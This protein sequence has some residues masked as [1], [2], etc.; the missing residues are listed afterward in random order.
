MDAMRKI[1][2]QQQNHLESER[3]WRH[4]H[5]TTGCSIVAMIDV[6]HIGGNVTVLMTAATVP[7]KPAVPIILCQR[8]SQ[9]QPFQSKDVYRINLCAMRDDVWPNRMYAMVFPTAQMVKTKQIVRLKDAVAI[10]SGLSNTSSILLVIIIA[11][12]RSYRHTVTPNS[13]RHNY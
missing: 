6:C 10:N 3:T 1:V 8:P 12:Q 11:I 7:M 2:Q 4:Q 5:A 13:V 9:R